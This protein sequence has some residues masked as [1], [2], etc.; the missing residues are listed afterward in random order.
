MHR[1]NETAQ[2]CIDLNAYRLCRSD[3]MINSE[4][5]AFYHY[6]NRL[7]AGRKA[8][9]RSEIDTRD[10]ACDARNLFILENLG[11]GDI[12]FRL[13]GTAVIRAIGIELRGTNARAIMATDARESFAAL[14]AETL[15]DPGI[16]YAR[17]RNTADE[18]SV[19]EI[20]LLP[21]RS[22]LGLA[23]RLIGCLHP[24][25]PVPAPNNGVPLRFRIESMRIDP[26]LTTVGDFDLLSDRTSVEPTKP[27]LTHL[28]GAPDVE[29]RL[30]PIEGGGRGAGRN[31]DQRAHLRV[32]R[33]ELAGCRPESE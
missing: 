11:R 31:R 12:R 13:A 2:G 19:W 15:E 23:D 20:N 33:H 25:T 10:V 4:L 14:I 3:D 28:D 30:V 5:R 7:R 17:L 29:P 1:V 32:V 21:L 8:P 16:G 22:N 27:V 9:L 18:S 26:I 6:W 24:L